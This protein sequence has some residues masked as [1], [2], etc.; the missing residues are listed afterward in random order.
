MTEQRGEENW[1]KGVLEMRG[2]WGIM[3]MVLPF[4]GLRMI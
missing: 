3:S 1:G 4:F 2:E